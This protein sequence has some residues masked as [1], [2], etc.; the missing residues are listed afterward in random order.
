[1][2]QLID[3]YEDHKADRD[4]FEILAFHDAQAKNFTELDKKL[5]PII[6]NRWGGRPLPFPI[7]LDSTGETIE[8]FGISAFP[9]I[10]LIDPEGRLVGQAKTE[11]LEMHLLPLAERARKALDRNVTVYLSDCT[12]KQASEMI[13]RA[14]K[15]SVTLD[16]GALQ[17]AGVTPETKVPLTLAAMISARSALHLVLDAFGLDVATTP[18]GLKVVKR[19]PGSSPSRPLSIPQERC[20]RRIE[21]RLKAAASFRLDK[22]TLEEVASYFEKQTTENFVLDPAGRKSGAIDPKATVS[23]SAVDQPLGAAIERM[24]RPLGLHLEV[25]D[26]VV[27]IAKAP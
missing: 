14:A 26:E 7:L 4:K 21:Q 2:P 3:F 22:A 11:E 10:V 19:T 24:L 25:R 9:T 12:L 5:E 6:K 1:L 18:E 13:S 23:G 17:S 8:K 15:V 27:I 16:P 20:A